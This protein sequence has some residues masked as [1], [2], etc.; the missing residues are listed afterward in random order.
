MAAA[1]LWLRA[2]SQDVEWVK[3]N[4]SSII[5]ALKKPGSVMPI[6]QTAGLGT[7]TVVNWQVV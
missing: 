5:P 4:A 7:A 1:R 2:G 6:I 3:R